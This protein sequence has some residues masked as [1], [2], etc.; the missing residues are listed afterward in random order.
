MKTAAHNDSKVGPSSRAHLSKLTT[1]GQETSLISPVRLSSSV[2][3]AMA[4][5]RAVADIRLDFPKPGPPMTSKG[6]LRPTL[7]NSCCQSTRDRLLAC[8]DSPPA[9]GIL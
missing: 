6:A 8:L 4:I 3:A 9:E 1:T 5:C 2:R 7:S